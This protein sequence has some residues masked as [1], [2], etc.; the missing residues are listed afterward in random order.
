[1]GTIPWLEKNKNWQATVKHHDGT[2]AAIMRGQVGGD[3][4]GKFYLYPDG[5]RPPAHGEPDPGIGMP[6]YSEDDIRGMIESGVLVLVR[7]AI[8]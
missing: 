4:E 5:W 2:L 1:M 6:Q 7:G 3:F 8:P